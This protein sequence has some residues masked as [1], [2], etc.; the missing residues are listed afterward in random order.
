[1]KDY[2]KFYITGIVF[3]FLVGCSGYERV[4]KS[5][6][7]KLKYSEALRYYN[8]EN[9]SRAAA[10][11]DQIAPVLRGTAQA[12]TVYYYQAMSYYNQHD[13]IL[14]GHYF[15]MFTRTYGAS[16]FVENAE[17]MG[18][19]CY[20]MQSPRPSLDQTNTVQA[21][22]AFQLYLIKYPDS[23]KTKQVE[24]YLNELRNKLVEKSYMSAKL[25]FDLED[26]KAS[27]VAL[28]NSLF[29]FPDTK[30]REE[31]MFMLVKS[32]Y[33][34]AFKSV[35]SKQKERYQD[36]IDEYYSFASEF[37]DSKYI[38]EA[39]RFYNNAIDFLGDDLDT[40]NESIQN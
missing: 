12:D 18:A 19:Y 9:Y 22:Q 40:V 20:Y 31:I 39:K 8:K 10:L 14:S 38:K 3:I 24:D 29:K 32:S 26:Y 21:I 34:L 28:N 35:K 27:L 2:Q 1:M 33:M 13:Y 15:R 5:S 25:Y 30:Y 37:P 4:L 6:D 16:P 11:F 17:F 23:E 36:T 7:Y